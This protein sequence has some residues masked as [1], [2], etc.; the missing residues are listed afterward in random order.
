[1][2]YYKN[3]DLADIIYFCVFDK[4]WKTEQWYP[5]I[6]YNDYAISD[7]GRIKSFKRNN[8]ILLKQ[9]VNKRGYLYVC[10]RNLYGVKSKKTHQLLAICLLNHKPNGL[11]I[12]V[13]HI[14]NNKLN[15]TLSNLQLLTHRD[16]VI[17]GIVKK[18]SK[19]NGVSWNKCSN[20]WISQIQ[21]NGKKKHLGLFIYEIEANN[22]YKKAL[23]KIEN[24]F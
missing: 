17:K 22:A 18:T 24:E 11:N 16:N 3:L 5:V 8:I 7:L 4:I 12:V 21:I 6:E 2:E 9:R 13:D 10:L 1:M 19:Y 20:K 15:N 23:K 14:D